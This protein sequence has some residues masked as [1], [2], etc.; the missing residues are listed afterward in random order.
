[1]SERTP[2]ELLEERQRLVDEMNEGEAP[3]ADTALELLQ[4]VYRSPKVPLQTRMRAAAIAIQFESPKLAVTAVSSMDGDHFAARLER[5]A[6]RSRAPLVI[7]HQPAER[8][9]P[10]APPPGIRGRSGAR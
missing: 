2:S 5:A 10:E 9:L 3:A 6:L 8:S 7:D 4:V 1:M